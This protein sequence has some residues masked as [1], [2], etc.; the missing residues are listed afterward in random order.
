[1]KVVI[2]VPEYSSEKGLLYKW[3]EGYV[4]ESKLAYGACVIRANRAGLVSL[5]R[6][7]LELAQDDV[8]AGYH[9]HFDDIGVLEP[10]SVPLIV[11]KM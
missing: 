4:I 9:H 10:G 11:E 7:L 8:P 3:D 5:A 6:H 2:D 1:M